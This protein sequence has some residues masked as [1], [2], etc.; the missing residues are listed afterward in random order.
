MNTSKATMSTSSSPLSSPSRSFKNAVMV[1]RQSGLVSESG[2]FGKSQRFNRKVM[3]MGRDSPKGEEYFSRNRLWKSSDEV[4]REATLGIGDRP[5]YVSGHRN[6]GPGSY[7]LVMSHAKA[8]SPLDGAEFCTRTLK[9][10]LKSSM[11]IDGVV[12]PGPKYNIKE[13][14]GSN[15]PKYSLG[16][17]IKQVEDHTGPGPGHNFSDHNSIGAFVGTLSMPDLKG[18]SASSLEASGGTKRCVKSTF[19]VAPRF[20]QKG[21]AKPDKD[22]YYAHSKIWDSETYL[23][24]SRSCSLGGGQRT[25]FSASQHTASPAS[26]DYGRYTSSA[27]KTSPI[28]GFADRGVSPVRYFSKK[29]GR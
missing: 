13:Q 5:A 12:S 25:D 26:Y 22:L 1:S 9:P 27:K 10:R 29:L 15:L 4:G 2:T 21:F 6:V 19:G 23:S 20:P 28:D 3:G 18:G 24:N 16:A 7:D 11:A 14:P 8:R 17:R